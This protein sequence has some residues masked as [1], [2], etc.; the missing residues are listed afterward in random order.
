MKNGR[1][2]MHGGKSTGPRTAEGRERSRLANTKHGRYSRET[3]KK[4]LL[5]W[6]SFEAIKVHLFI[7]DRNQDEREKRY[8]RDADDP[9]C[10]KPHSMDALEGSA[11]LQIYERWLKVDPA[12]REIKEAIRELKD[13]NRALPDGT[14]KCSR[15]PLPVLSEGRG[16][17]FEEIEDEC[18]EAM[19]KFL[20][21][22]G[23]SGS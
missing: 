5:P 20:Q 16:L 10:D 18:R 6:L 2:R 15:I 8:L 17:T 9:L 3:R 23:S 13:P 12:N 11:L 1:C 21:Q 22:Y 4:K 7:H 14:Y 19:E